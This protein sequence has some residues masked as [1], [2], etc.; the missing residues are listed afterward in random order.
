[1]FQINLQS[2]HVERDNS[3]RVVRILQS[4]A[5]IVI[6][7]SDAESP[8]LWANE[9]GLRGGPFESKVGGV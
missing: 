7:K 3:F 1:V 9:T 4:P 5:Y 8:R 6:V 2:F